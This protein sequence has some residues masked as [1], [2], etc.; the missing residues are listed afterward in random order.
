MDALILAAGLGTRLGSLTADRPKALVEIAGKTMLEHLLLKLKRQG[1][2]RVAVNVHHYAD[3]I[4]DYLNAND[5]FHMEIVI[6]D[7]SD[8]LLDT[9]GGIRKA[10]HLLG[11]DQPLLVHN[12]DIFS[13]TDLKAL[14]NMHTNGKADATLLVSDRTASR[15]LHFS[16][17][18]RLR[19]WSNAISGEFRSPF[20][21]FDSME[22]IPLAFQGIH[23]LSGSV[24]PLLDSVD[25]ESFGITG[26]Y[27]DNA[28]ALNLTAVS[29]SAES[30]IDAGKPEALER[31]ALIAE[32]DIH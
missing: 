17:D 30:W 13:H 9:G 1:F 12:V 32:S 3:M 4:V 21:D 25:E 7:E 24:L 15:K 29:N 27:V 16:N 19:G 5:N 26:F 6:S 20:N 2:G 22:C 18:M 8:K 23:V 14:Y 28:A 10:M 11:G 31:A